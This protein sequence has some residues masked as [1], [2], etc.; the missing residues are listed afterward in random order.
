MSG[1]ALFEPR[2]ELG[3]LPPISVDADPNGLA[4][5]HHAGSLYVADGRGGAIFRTDGDRPR[6]LTTIDPGGPANRIGGLAVTPYGTLYVTRLGPGHGAIIRVDPDGRSEP[7][8][9]P[10]QRFWRVGVTYDAVDHVLYATQ[11]LKSKAGYHGGAIEEID[12]VDGHASTILDG[13]IKPVGVAK[14]GSTLVV[15]DAGARAVFRVD[16]V[17]G[18]AV[19]RATLADDL[20]RPDSVCACGLDAVLITTY[21]EATGRGALRRLSLGGASRVLASGVWEPRGVAT[22]GSL[23][24]VAHRRSGHVLVFRHTA[25]QEGDDLTPPQG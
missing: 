1:V 6:K 15:T 2:S 23:A 24:F 9:K 16:L 11:Y 21:D 12:L 13:F 18:R 17:S 8:A 5:D 19:R 4:F 3:D 20:G 10:S 22:D 25:S 7:L 14:L